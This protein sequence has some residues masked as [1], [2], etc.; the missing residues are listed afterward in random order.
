MRNST[1]GTLTPV[2][3]TI[4]SCATGNMIRGHPKIRLPSD[5][6]FPVRSPGRW[7]IPLHVVGETRLSFP[8]SDR[9]STFEGLVVE[10]LDVVVLPAAPLRRSM[11][12]PS[13]Q[14]NAKLFL[15][16]V[17]S[18]TMVL[19][20]LRNKLCCTSWTSAPFPF[21]IADHLAWRVCRG[22]S[23]QRYLSRQWIRLG[24]MHGRPKCLVVISLRTVALTKQ[25]V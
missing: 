14:P 20:K 11:I 22:R 16:M 19:N 17:P 7:L 10:N 15:S 25:S 13:A 9:E 8:R 18:T 12:S 23:A 1:T 4:D 21:H 24:T 2:R 5:T 3:I 6:Q